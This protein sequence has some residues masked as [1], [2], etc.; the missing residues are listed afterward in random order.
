[1]RQRLVAVQAAAQVSGASVTG[2]ELGSSELSFTP[3]PIQGGDYHFAIG[4]AGNC[5]LVL[6]TVVLALLHAQQPSTVRI[7]GGAHNTMAPPLQFLQRAYL[8]LLA[9]MGAGSTSS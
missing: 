9:H 1:M 6:Q 8:P 2:A 4:S 7:G 5:A 3:G